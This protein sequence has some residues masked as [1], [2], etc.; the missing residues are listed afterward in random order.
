MKL[1]VFFF[2]FFFL[3]SFHFSFF[4]LNELIKS[5]SSSSSLLLSLFSF[6]EIPSFIG[7]M[8]ELLVV[9]FANNRVPLSIPKE[10]LKLKKLRKL[11]LRGTEILSLPEG[12][13]SLP[14]LVEI[15]FSPSVVCSF[16]SGMFSNYPLQISLVCYF[17]LFFIL[18]YFFLV[19]CFV[20]S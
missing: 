2:L 20:V 4:F 17:F 18:F 11:Y 16:P 10:V 1:R 6:S 15:D 8:E 9:S 3:F 19:L 5:P 13:G 14:N 7:E 12:L